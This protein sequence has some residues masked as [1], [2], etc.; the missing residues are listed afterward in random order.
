MCIAWI[1]R[2]RLQGL[3]SA[4]C[5]PP[6]LAPSVRGCGRSHTV[7][8]GRASPP[9][10][11]ARAQIKAA[12]SP[13]QQCAVRDVVAAVGD[14]AEG[15]RADPARRRRGGRRR[16][17]AQP[18]AAGR[19]ARLPVRRPL[20]PGAAGALDSVHLPS[21]ALRAP[22][23]AGASESRSTDSWKAVRTT[24]A[25]ASGCST[26]HLRRDLAP[27]RRRGRGGGGAAAGV[28]LRPCPA[29]GRVVIA[30]SAE[31]R[32]AHGW[33]VGFA[34]PLRAGV[35]WL[36]AAQQSDAK[37]DGTRQLPRCGGD[38]GGPGHATLDAEQQAATSGSKRVPNV[39]RNSLWPARKRVDL[40]PGNCKFPL[41]RLSL[42]VRKMGANVLTRWKMILNPCPGIWQ[43][44]LRE[45]VYFFP[46][47]GREF[48]HDQCNWILHLCYAAL[49]AD[50]ELPIAPPGIANRHGSCVR[51]AAAPAMQSAR[52]PGCVRRPPRRGA[53]L[54]GG[55]HRDLGEA[56]AGNP[57]FPKASAPA[58]CSRAPPP[59]AAPA[60]AIGL[61]GAL[62]LQRE[63]YTMGDKEAAPGMPR[64]RQS[65]R[66]L[67]QGP[68]E[69]R[70]WLGTPYSTTAHSP[71]R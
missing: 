70:M 22:G 4:A 19:E 65:S 63:A 10:C 31:A 55:E 6:L 52:R 28:A 39:N 16:R 62:R 35:E 29:A 49:G 3:R 23:V 41:G 69:F 9:V 45:I 58:P 48:I 36:G 18:A 64:Y 15:S 61:R 34:T 33:R 67:P 25:D 50:A 51:Q 2:W 11:S 7:A 42:F 5:R 47:N 46:G 20:L 53:V 12:P 68:N 57:V 37:G 26:P 43:I 14:A 24:A 54:G 44:F 60:L 40:P 38:G 17:A 59:R 30:Y 13:R 21:D 27:A 71:Q 56:A 66:Q 8:G 1:S 32:A